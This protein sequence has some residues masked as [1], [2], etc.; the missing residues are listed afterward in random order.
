MRAFPSFLGAISVVAMALVGGFPAPAHAGSERPVAASG[1]GAHGSFSPSDLHI[2]VGDAVKWT[3]TD[4][5][6]TVVSDGG[7]FR[8]PDAFAADYEPHSFS[9]TFTKPGRYT[10]HCSLAQMVGVIEVADPSGATTTTEPPTT[11]TT[12]GLYK[13]S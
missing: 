1:R 3:A 5:D 4:G 13:P 10:Y 11:T 9:Y 8:S 7:A 6:H 12:R 2:S